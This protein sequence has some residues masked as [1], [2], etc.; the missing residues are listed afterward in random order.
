MAVSITKSKK[1]LAEEKKAELP[2]VEPLGEVQYIDPATLSIEELVDR[3][4]SLE[5]QVNA[6]KLNPVFT[7]FDET[8]KQLMAR[9]AEYEPLVEISITGKHW[10]LEAGA[11]G[12]NARKLKEDAI[13]KLRKMLG[14]E[15]FAKLAKVN[16]GDV[17]KYCTPDQV[18]QVINDDVGY[19]K[20]RKITIKHLG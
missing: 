9:L 11:C 4:G 16:I 2:K 18:A 13:P 7:H 6:M 19:S 8:A 14:D 3:Y 12:K 1:A 10:L 5:D 15:T 17:E 20:N